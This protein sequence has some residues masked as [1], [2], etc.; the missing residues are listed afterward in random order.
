MRKLRLLCVILLLLLGSHHGVEAAG[1]FIETRGLHFVLNGNP[2]FANG[3][4]AYWMMTL[5]SDPSRRDKVSSAL[6]DASRHGLSVARTWAFSDGG[7]NA[8]QN[9]PGAYSEQIF[10]VSYCLPFIFNCLCGLLPVLI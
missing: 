3:F 6:S 5:A 10:Q 1:G 9:S 8:L 4:N 7:S 2:F